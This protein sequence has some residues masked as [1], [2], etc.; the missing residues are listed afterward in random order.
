MMTADDLQAA[1]FSAAE[2]EKMVDEN[3]NYDEE[4]P[5]FDDDGN[6][7]DDDDFDEGA[8]SST[9]DDQDEKD[10]DQDD[11]GDQD[12]GDAQEAA[13]D[14]ADKGTP[15]EAEEFKPYVA[16]ALVE[17]YDEK[18]AEFATKKA[19]LSE[20]LDNGDISL[21]D[22]IAQRDQLTK[23]ET[24]LTTTQLI[25]ETEIKRKSQEAA[26]TWEN[27]QKEFF[28]KQTSKIYENKI[29]STAL[30]TAVIDLAKDPANAS[31]TGA[32]VLAEADK[33]VRELMG[34]KSEQGKPAPKGGNR[35]PNLELVP[36]TLG[37]LPAA[38]DDENNADEFAGIKNLTGIEKEKAI[39]RFTPEQEERYLRAN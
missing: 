10:D 24:T 13:A 28:T 34:L 27:D 1:G 37:G 3:G 35:K 18:I 36:K 2:I 26:Q 22:F 32:W 21:S 5:T 38:A 31:K 33:Q 6:E 11:D 16:P 25:A 14:T 4:N 17:D 23:D 15:A 7:V 12:E 20:Q 9:D 39:A 29:L 30:N 19:A 8:E